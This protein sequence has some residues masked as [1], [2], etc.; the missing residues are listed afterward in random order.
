MSGLTS[1][2]ESIP[3]I[4][5]IQN[6]N[7]REGDISEGASKYDIKEYSTDDY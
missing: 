4:E 3:N 7:L 1:Y 2:N 5:L 6:K